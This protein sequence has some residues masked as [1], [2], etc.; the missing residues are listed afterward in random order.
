MIRTQFIAG[1]LLLLALPVWAQKATLRGRVTDAE[2]AHPLANV[3]VV[4]AQTGLFAATDGDGNYVLENVPEGRFLLVVSTTGYLPADQNVELKSGQESQVNITLRR[5]PTNNA[6][7]IPTVTLDEAEAETEGAGEV[8]NLLHASRDV[9]Q[10]IANF[11]WGFF[12][13]RER[14]YES[15]HFPLF[16]NGVSINDPETGIAFF[17]EFGGLNDVL[18]QRETVIGIE[19]S[20]FA[21]NTVGGATRLDTRASVQRKQIRATYALSNRTYNQRVMLT[22]STGLMP[23]GWAVSVSGSHRWA[24]EAWYD[25]TFFDAYSYF[26]S[27]DKKFGSTHSL[28]LTVLGA[29]S[30]RGRNTDTFQ[31]M[32]DLAGTTRYNPSWGYWNGEKRNANVTH[33]HQPIALLRY[34]YTPSRRLGMTLTA[35]GQAGERGQ[36]RLDWFD[37]N[38]PNPDYYRR[39][40]S[41]YPDSASQADW[42]QMLRDNESLRQIDWVN[43][44]QGNTNGLDSQVDAE[45]IPGNVVTGNRSTTIL[46]DFR[47]DSREAGFNG[48][49]RYN[50]SDRVTLNGGANYLWYEGKNFKV[51]EDMLGG[52]FIVDKNPFADE[53]LQDNDVRTPNN[54]IR[55]GDRFGWDYDENIRRAGG[56]LQTQVNLR[57]FNFFVGGEYNYLKFWRTGYM[58]NSRAVNNSLGDSDILSFN[59]WGAKAGVTYKINGRNYVYANGYYGTRPP[60]FRDVFLSPRTRNSVL[61]NPEASEVQS[62]EG[63]YVLRAPRV[64]ARLTGYA[65]QFTNE[66]EALIL[67]GQ[68]ANVFGTEVR[69]GVDHLHTGIEAAVEWKATAALTLSAATNLGYYRYNSRPEVSFYED[70]TNLAAFE[71]YTV[72]QEG[73]LVPR[74]PQT[75]ASAAVRYEGKKFWFATLTF[76]W[77]DDMW[78]DFD[79]ARRTADYASQLVVNGIQP[80]SSSWNLIMDQTKAPAAYTLDFFG[81]KSWRVRG[82]YFIY[83]NAGVNNLLNN[84]DIILSGREAYFRN[85]QDVDD[86]RLYSNEITYAIGLNYFVSLG[87]RI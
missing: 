57:K 39:L 76:N 58:Q 11:G 37:S 14:G 56:W 9:Y 86:T 54:I 68:V 22:A 46:A 12:R 62:V 45:G 33:S 32:Y 27:V 84:R 18:R 77:V 5:D 80:G 1:L 40:P 51:A 74:T 24:E 31:E 60:Q 73:F 3:S 64:R 8:A 16:L 34:D 72:Y 15:E 19:A 67:F 66:T 35:Y 10:N 70:N 79:R 71:N 50:L 81:G 55:E 41:T 17:G 23:G 42:A 65:T 30:R 87:L 82:K 53:G 44:Y 49:A 21:F 13:F 4:L 75:A 2:D 83:L 38:N 48:I 28:N 47:E 29:P 20:D 85:F 25:G 78:Y 63:G 52:D 59:T 7:E 61:A 36:T 43:I 26:V 6:G 69:R